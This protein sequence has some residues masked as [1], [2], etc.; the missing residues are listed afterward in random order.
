M[1]SRDREDHR[2]LLLC[3]PLAAR[4]LQIWAFS[5]APP[6]KKKKKTIVIEKH[7]MFV[8]LAFPELYY[9]DCGDDG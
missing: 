6:P 4:V 2:L 1:P 9:N 8:H 7:N 3:Q 5:P